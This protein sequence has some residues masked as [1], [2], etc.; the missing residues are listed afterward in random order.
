MLMI[1]ARGGSNSVRDVIFRG[2]PFH[3]NVELK[4]RFV[5]ESMTRAN[6]L[7]G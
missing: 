3:E 6:K 4:N 1:I 7:L 2:D 5:Y